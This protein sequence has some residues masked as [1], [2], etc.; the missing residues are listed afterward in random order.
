M[1]ISQLE[2]PTQKEYTIPY[3]P[4]VFYVLLLL[5]LSILMPMNIVLVGSDVV[6]SLKSDPT[7][8]N[9]P[10]GLPDFW[11]DFL[12]PSTPEKCHPAFITDDMNLRTNS[13]MPI[14]KYVLRGAYPKSTQHNPANRIYPVPYLANKLSNCELH[15]ITLRVDIPAVIMKYQAEVYCT[16]EGFW[17]ESLVSE[18]PNEVVFVITYTRGTIDLAPD[19]MFDHITLTLNPNPRDPY[20]QRSAPAYS[21]GELPINSS[22]SNNV[23]AVLDGMHSDLLGAIWAQAMIRGGVN[24]TSLSLHKTY[25]ALWTED[26]GDYCSDTPDATCGSI[27]DYNWV[28]FAYDAF[29]NDSVFIAPFN[30]TITNSIIALRDAIMI[31]LGNAQASSNIYLNKTYFNEVIRTDPFHAESASILTNLPGDARINSSDYWHFCSSWACINT[32]WAGAF[33]NVTEHQP[34]RN[35]ILPYQPNGTQATALNFKY[36]CPTF[37]RKPINSMLVSVFTVTMLTSLYALFQW[38]MPMVEA[39][40]QKWQQAT[41]RAM[42]Q[43]T[44]DQADEEHHLVGIPMARTNTFDSS[45]T[46]YDPVSQTEKDKTGRTTNDSANSNSEAPAPTINLSEPSPPASES[47]KEYGDVDEDDDAPPPFPLPNSIQ[48]SSGSSQ[49]PTV[50]ANSSITLVSSA[51]AARQRSPSP[52]SKRMPP[53]R[54]PAIRLPTVSTNGLLASNSATQRG[55]TIFIPSTGGLALPP[56][57]TKR[58]PNVNT[59]GKARAKV[60]LAP[61]H[62]ALDWADL[63]SSGVDLRGVTELQRITP[64]MLKEHRSR[65]DAWSAF[66]GKVYNITPYLAYHPGGEKELMRVAGRDGSKLFGKSTTHAWVNLDFMLDGCLVGFLVPEE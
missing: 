11:P 24:D 45:N 35:I 42:N 8:I 43:D 52:D 41:A 64:S 31:D 66:G 37:R 61:G 30:I 10:W 63:K 16:L 3:L 27:A 29:G 9:P 28:L 40:Y 25:I 33:R 44:E 13:S 57:T 51:P 54:L 62:G 5:L 48:R 38:C 56:S 58:M 17:D 39:R 26:T 53:P 59:K 14:F 6:T 22:S 32:P 19:D 65:D 36:L 7:S 60:A 46:L 15:T 49:P 4:H 21:L 23:L 50:T 18:T 34:L 12:R 1:K 47:G 20:G 55:N 2:Y